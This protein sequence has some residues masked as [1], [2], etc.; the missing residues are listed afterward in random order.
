MNKVCY[1][2][3]DR[4]AQDFDYPAH[5]IIQQVRVYQSQVNMVYEAVGIDTLQIF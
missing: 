2:D 3:V 5:I 4:R 1:L